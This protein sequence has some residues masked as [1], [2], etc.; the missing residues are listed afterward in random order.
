MGGVARDTMQA[1]RAAGTK[2]VGTATTV[3]EA[4]ALEDAEVDAIALQGA[5]A[6]AHRGTFLGRF[7][8]SLVPIARS[9]PFVRIVNDYCTG[10]AGSNPSQPLIGVTFRCSDACRW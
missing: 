7:E 5:E 3:A 6:G 9:C 8:D 1:F 4:V 10:W 2:L